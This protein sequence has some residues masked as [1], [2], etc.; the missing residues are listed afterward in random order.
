MQYGIYCITVLNSQRK[1]ELFLPARK[2]MIKSIFEIIVKDGSSSGTDSE[3]LSKLSIKS[4]QNLRKVGTAS[5]V[6]G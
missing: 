6:E 1:G 5:N 3:H 4:L 2:K